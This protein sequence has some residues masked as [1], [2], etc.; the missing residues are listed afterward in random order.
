[1]GVSLYSKIEEK[2]AGEDIV[3]LD[4]GT[5]TEIQRRG[6]PMSGDTWSADANLTHP[7]IV[8]AVHEGYVE[9]GADLI[10][11]NTFGTSPLLF[12][13]LGRDDD[14]AKIDAAAVAIAREAAQERVPVAGSFSVMGPMTSA[15]GGGKSRP[16]WK[17]R[18]VKDLMKR[19][20]ESLA[21]A[22]VDL[23]TMEM[24]GDR[25][26]S[27]WATEAAVATGLPVWVGVSVKRNGEGLL[28]GFDRED[29]AFEEFIG[30]LTKSG[31]QVLCIMHTSP[32]DTT[33]AIPIVQ[34]KW[35]GPLGA[36]PESGYFEP[37]DW[38]FVD[39]I[40]VSAFVEMARLWVERG[41][42]LVGGCCGIGPDHIRALAKAFKEEQE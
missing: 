1:M 2:L 37:P 9:A 6:A 34:A 25:D 8:R 10:I 40:P 30:P 7:D 19:K 13:Y 11:A 23:I 12:N 29:T 14:L 36:Y 16:Q 3:I 15:K 39:I 27:L 21:S 35:K 33:T 38:K 20:A 22:G 32:N 26:H 31:A 17:K 4:G 41:V 18:Q 24:M 5:G 42:R 28:T